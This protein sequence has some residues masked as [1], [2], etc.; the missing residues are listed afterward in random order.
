VLEG[1]GLVLEVFLVRVRILRV[2]ISIE[3]EC[4]R[5]HGLADDD[6][7]TADLS[8]RANQTIS[9]ELIV[10]PMLESR[11]LLPI[12]NGE[13]LPEPFRLLVRSIEGG[14][15]EAAVNGRLVKHD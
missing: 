12:G 9:I 13:L 11:R 2:L 6:I 1:R 5:G 14:A 10:G 3:V 4:V 15:E 7:I 8:A